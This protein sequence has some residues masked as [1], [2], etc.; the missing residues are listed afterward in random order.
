LR[1][2]S[3]THRT[4]PRRAREFPLNVVWWDTQRR[5]RLNRPFV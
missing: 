4:L 2:A 5:L 1:V 3:A